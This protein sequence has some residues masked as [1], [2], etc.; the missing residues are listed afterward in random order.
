LRHGLNIIFQANPIFGEGYHQHR[1]CNHLQLQVCNPTL[2]Q[3]QQRQKTKKKKEK[4]KEKR[5]Q[6]CKMSSLNLQLAHYG[7]K[8]D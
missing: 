1:E 3:Q 6:K 7:I 5:R 8:I 4:R 2:Q